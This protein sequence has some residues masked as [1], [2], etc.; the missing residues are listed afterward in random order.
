MVEDN[1]NLV[2]IYLFGKIKAWL[3]SY[4]VFCGTGEQ[5]CL[6]FFL[7]EQL[8]KYDACP[9]DYGEALKD[10]ISLLMKER[11]RCIEFG[12]MN[13]EASATKND[14]RKK[15][16]IN[17]YLYKKI[18]DIVDKDKTF[19]IPKVASAMV[20]MELEE[21]FKGFN[22]KTPRT[23]D[24]MRVRN[25]LKYSDSGIKK[26]LENVSHKTEKRLLFNFDRITWDSLESMSGQIG[27]S[28]NKFLRH[29]IMDYIIK[30][31]LGLINIEKYDTAAPEENEP[32]SKEEK[33]VKL[34]F[35]YEVW[36]FIERISSCCSIPQKELLQYI[37]LDY[38]DR[39]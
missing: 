5:S 11:K 20:H 3:N 13:K 36:S 19:S 14:F 39:N 31:K 26:N 21:L 30:N 23:K 35:S 38:I 15:I 22:D 17:D 10:K 1:K 16:E 29:I 6:V 4:I 28:K 7:S 24:A 34:I 18:N 37:I 32:E 33:T 8:K 12:E 25:L 2:G 27:L 9:G